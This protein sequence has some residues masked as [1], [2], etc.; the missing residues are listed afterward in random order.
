MYFSTLAQSVKFCKSRSD[1][2]KP[3]CLI[4]SHRHS[5]AWRWEY[6]NELLG[7]AKIFE[8]R[9]EPQ[10]ARELE[11]HEQVT[12]PQKYCSARIVAEKAKLRVFLWMGFNEVQIN[13]ILAPCHPR[14]SG[15]ACFNALH[16]L[17]GF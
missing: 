17:I 7:N 10:P 8:N 3:C 11:F 6:V 9:N 12:K 4:Y 16:W 15:R 2:P 1:W 13:G 14:W 5:V